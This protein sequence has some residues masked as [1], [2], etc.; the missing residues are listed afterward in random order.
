MKKFATL[1]SAAILT[2][3]TAGAGFAVTQEEVKAFVDE[4][5][6]YIKA[7]GRDAAMAEFNKK[8]GKFVRGELYVFALQFDGTTLAN[9]G[10]PKMVGK[11]LFEMNLKDAN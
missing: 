3:C 8:D 11:N 7:N 9:G 10:N 5:A 1:L 6:S 4:A 2:I